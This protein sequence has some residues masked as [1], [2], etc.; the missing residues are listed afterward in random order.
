LREANLS[1][2]FNKRTLDLAKKTFAEILEIAEDQ[3]KVR[4]SLG[5]KPN[6]WKIF[7]D[8]DNVVITIIQQLCD[9]R[10]LSRNLMLQKTV[11]KKEDDKRKEGHDLNE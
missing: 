8:Q 5:E 1:D 11:E 6:L 4:G 2:Q 7:E 9:L 3:R 10:T